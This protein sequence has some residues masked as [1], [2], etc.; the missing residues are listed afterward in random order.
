MLSEKGDT[1]EALQK[2]DLAASSSEQMDVLMFSDPASYAQRVGLGMVA[3]LDDFIAK[4]GYKVAEDYKV[5]TIKR[6]HLRVA[7]QI[8]S[9]VCIAEQN[10]SKRSG[11]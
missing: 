4:D 2:L 8:Q 6:K 9:M 5:D 3:K 11:P 1:Q 10:A 7:R